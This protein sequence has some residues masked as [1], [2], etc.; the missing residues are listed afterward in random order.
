MIDIFIDIFYGKVTL[1]SLL[2]FYLCVF[3][4]SFLWSCGLVFFLKD[5]NNR[6]K[7]YYVGFFVFIDMSIFFLG[8]IV[9]T[10]LTLYIIKFKERKYIKKVSSIDH[11]EFKAEF[12]SIKRIFGEGSMKQMMGSVN[13]SKKMKLKALGALSLN[14]SKE[15]VKLLKTS[16]ADSMDE[17][18]L[19]SF[20][21]IDKLE[22]EI[23]TK[24]K[25]GVDRIKKVENY[26]DKDKMETYIM[27]LNQY[28]DLVYFGLSDK[29]MEGF[30][31]EKIEEYAKLALEIS[32]KSASIYVILGKASM[33]KN[34]LPL[35]H[36]YFLKAIRNGADNNYIRPYL[37]EIAFKRRDFVSVG[38]IMREARGLESNNNL[39]PVVV[40]WQN[41]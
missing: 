33:Y 38:Q 6:S 5:L 29:S 14:N 24:I 7:A 22:K 18:R 8:I 27:I 4:I 16:L 26:E 35:A 25:D 9:T 40:Q 21:L 3:V 19:Y 23:N 32:D 12:R 11:S 31:I 37:A 34:D 30:V 28:W 10:I 20:S 15:N 13:V 1:I 17:V 39:Q 41:I 2:L 36:E